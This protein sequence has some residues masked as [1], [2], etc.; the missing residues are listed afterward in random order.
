[1]LG[2]VSITNH[3]EAI[4]NRT[5]WLNKALPTLE[6][7]MPNVSIVMPYYRR[8]HTI[9]Q[10]LH[11][12]SRVDYDLSKIKV[13]IVDDGS[14]KEEFPS[15]GDFNT[16]FDIK[17][18]YQE[19]KG[20]RVAAA[21]NLGVAHAQHEFVILLDCD[22]SV[23]PSFVKDHIER[24]YNHAYV[25][26]IGLRNSHGAVHVEE[27][28]LFSQKCPSQIGSKIS[29]D[30]RIQRIADTPQVL[31]SNSSWRLCSGGNIGFRKSTFIHI[32]EFNER[33][34]FW[35]GEDTEW[36][37]RAYKRGVYFALIPNVH[38]VHFDCLTSEYQVDR[39]TDRQKKNT[40]LRDLVPLYSK[41]EHMKGEVPY[42]SIFVTH[43]NKLEFLHT[44]LK[45]ILEATSY[46]F[47]IVLVDDCSDCT[48]EDIRS[49]VPTGILPH[50][51]FKR[52]EQ[53]KG[54]ELAYKEAISLCDGEYI[55]QLDADDYLLPKAIDKLIFK[56]RKCDAD[57]A[58]GKYKVL[59]E[60][61]LIDGWS[62]K[63]T[64]EMRLLR[65]MHYH[66]LRV[67]RS[68]AIHRVGGMRILGLEGAVDFSLYS[69]MELACKAVFCDVFTYVYRQV[70]DSITSTNF[71]AQVE[72]VRKVI[73]DNANLLSATKDYKITQV[74]ERLYN[75]EFSEQ[76]T[77]GYTKHL[78]LT[79]K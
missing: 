28:D 1:V 64:R 45:S 8:P 13:I 75:V 68:R 67:F 21:R 73:E 41:S 7:E 72:G 19:D 47:E 5:D 10:A 6:E 55:A 30:W 36:A 65:G 14:P 34:N 44:A 11:S 18:V 63:S 49:Q 59:K 33:F 71:A 23:K 15:L 4:G 22:L 60:G 9:L 25:V 26:S 16:T 51:K 27:L 76:D 40:L 37:Y 12:L 24:L 39:D 79:K 2:M 35:G 48:I 57:I 50:L 78:G 17:Y 32:G 38:A 29:E 66:P 77:V 31:E 53:H 52:L 42:V 69:Q 3:I 58:Y 43:Y 62:C 54:A 70:E 20:Y 46:R 56:L 74:K 61:E